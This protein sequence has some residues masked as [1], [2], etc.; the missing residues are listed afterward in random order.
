MTH[1]VIGSDGLARPPWAAHDE[2]L[3]NYYDTEWGMPIT[4]DQGMYE[5]LV[6]EG[7][8]AGLSW[9]TVLAKRPAFRRAFA[10]FDIPTVAAFDDDDVAR[11]R[12]DETII[13][14]VR[15][16]QAAITN[17][18]ATLALQE[19]GESLAAIIWS[20]QPERTYAPLSTDEIPSSSPESKALAA[21]LKKK[22][23]VFVG[24]TTMF[25]LMEATGVINTHMIGSWRR[26]PSR[27]PQ[28]SD[29]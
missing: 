9:R 19:A 5:R 28:S 26:D 3:R 2:L 4:D 22:G 8:Q 12:A 18:R 14:N 10:G 17:A 27:Q 13:R 7:F 23:F 25:A 21:E 15:K 16:I 6:L 29:N 24:P 20:H 1:V 11:L